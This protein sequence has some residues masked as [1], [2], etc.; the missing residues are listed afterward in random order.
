MSA[1]INEQSIKA[2]VINEIATILEVEQEK[3]K[4]DISFDRYGI[5]SLAIVELTDKLSTLTGKDVEP[6][7]LYDFPTIDQL[8]AHLAS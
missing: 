5:D 6:T 2:F 4:P 3:I 8:S 7:L 1:E